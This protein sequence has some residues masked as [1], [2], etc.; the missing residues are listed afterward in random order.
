MTVGIDDIRKVLKKEDGWFE[1]NMASKQ[2]ILDI[3][4]T[5]YEYI[6]VRVITGVQ[7]SGQLSEIAFAK[8]LAINFDRGTGWIKSTETR[9]DVDG[10]EDN[11]LKACRK[12]WQRSVARAKKEN[13]SIRN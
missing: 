1:P 10:W 4:L 12:M 6:E 9:I 3:K 13:C 2:Y 5:N 7:K 8:V 11:L